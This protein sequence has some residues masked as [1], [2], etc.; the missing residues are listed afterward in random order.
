MAAVFIARILA[1]GAPSPPSPDADLHIPTL[2]ALAINEKSPEPDQRAGDLS[3]GVWR[4]ERERAMGLEPT[5]SN[6][7]T[8][9]KNNTPQRAF[10]R[11]QERSR[12]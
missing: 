8:R 4:V 3:N 12:E 9:R 10:E 11:R 6:L 2:A 7:G 1:Q 5:T